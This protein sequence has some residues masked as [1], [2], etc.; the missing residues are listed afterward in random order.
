MLQL[1]T[2]IVCIPGF[3]EEGK[4]SRA[5]FQTGTVFDPP[6]LA[7]H[8]EAVGIGS[9]LGVFRDFG[10]FGVS[11]FKGTVDIEFA[12]LRNLYF[13]NFPPGAV[14]ED[15]AVE[16]N[17]TCG[18]LSAESLLVKSVDSF[19]APGALTGEKSGDKQSELSAFDGI[20]HRAVFRVSTVFK[21]ENGDVFDFDIFGECHSA[22]GV[23][24][25]AVQRDVHK[26]SVCRGSS[27][28]SGN[29]VRG[30]LLTVQLFHLRGDF[31]FDLH[32]FHGGTVFE[33][34]NIS[35]K[36]QF[37]VDGA[38]GAGGEDPFIGVVFLSGEPLFE[39]PVHEP[40]DGVG[41]EFHDQSALVFPCH[42]QITAG[43][44]H[45]KLKI[46]A[47]D[48]RRIPFGTGLIVGVVFSGTAEEGAGAQKDALRFG[49]RIF[50]GVLNGQFIGTVVIE[51]VSLVKTDIFED[52]SAG[53]EGD[54]H[55][56]VAFDLPLF[57]GKVVLFKV[58]VLLTF[59]TCGAS[60]THFTKGIPG[61]G[62]AVPVLFF[63]DQLFDNGTFCIK[64]YL[65][66]SVFVDQFSAG[67]ERR[68]QQCCRKEDFFHLYSSI[69]D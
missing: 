13:E 37:D 43:G 44:K 18:T 26:V 38:F 48:Q 5:S 33:G 24:E 30:I 51:L 65:K 1:N 47:L 8:H 15:T 59:G 56:I 27:F 45:G 36:G 35:G 29:F 31:A 40:C 46:F 6:I 55:G 67:Q 7:P 34:M 16:S 60:D 17:G 49:T 66:K 10:I 25:L 64:A 52:R 20:S 11:L 63:V 9:K 21:L 42:S 12:P 41:G 58:F 62:T 69:I 54:I 61:N 28:D 39:E 14:K 57:D 23:V 32:G 22:P 2:Q 53:G 50:K 3:G 19:G 68:Q 4:Y